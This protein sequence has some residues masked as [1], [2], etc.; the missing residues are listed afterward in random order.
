MTDSEGDAY[1]CY[2]RN[3]TRWFSSA[4]PWPGSLGA[5]P[6]CIDRQALRLPEHFAWLE[7]AAHQLRVTPEQQYRWA[8][9]I[10]LILLILSFSGAGYNLPLH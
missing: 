7:W 9:S 4:R 2:Q 1:L 10:C 8:V 5:K 6:G 3:S